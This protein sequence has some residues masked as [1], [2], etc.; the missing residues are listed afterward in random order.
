M[1]SDVGGV[2]GT[3]VA[4]TDLGT[5]PREAQ[6]RQAVERDPASR[7]AEQPRR[8]DAVQLTETA[9]RLREVEAA[10]GA[11]PVVDPSRVEAVQRAIVEGRFQ[12]D[13]NEVAVKFI[14]LERA[15]D[16]T[17]R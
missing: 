7:Q 12:P 5:R 14:E 2:S 8:D 9:S 11:Q 1:A 3:G 15:L 17:T 4:Q 13:T 10:L 6:E 16:E